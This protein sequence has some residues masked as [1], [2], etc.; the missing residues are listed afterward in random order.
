MRMVKVYKNNRYIYDPLYGKIYLPEFIWDIIPCPELQRLRE[1]RLANINSLCLIGGAS[2][3]RYEHAIGTTHL[4]KECI[5]SWPLLNPISRNEQKLF[6]LAA[7]LHD[8]TSAAF[9]HSVEYIE[10]R[11]GFEHDKSFKYAVM[12]KEK[13]NYQYKSATLEPI[14]YGMRRE[15]PSKISKE[16]FETIA[17]IISGKG[18]LGPLINS[19]M[20]LDNI[21][22]VFRLAYHI[23]IAKPGETPLKIA[24]S[25]YIENDKLIVRKEA[26]PF[27]EEWYE[28]RRKLYSLF[29]FNPEEFSAK[30]MLS[31]AIELARKSDHSFNWYDT[32]YEL[33]QKLSRISSET[34]LICSRLMK[35]DLYGCI[36]IFS[37]VKTDKYGTF[38]DRSRREE[39]E[40]ELR[41]ILR[42]KLGS[43]FKSAMV[44]I[45][46]IV[47]VNKAKRKVSLQA[48]DGS[49]VQIGT[50]SNQLLIGVFFK[51]ANL[52]MYKIYNIP[53]DTM[54]KIRNEISTYLSNVLEDPN[55]QEIE[56]YGEAKDL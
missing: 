17:E 31:E 13:A 42:K 35:A 38:S 12:R 8:V 50:S 15:L 34:S 18:R 36:V 32:D 41:K 29:L 49:A 22:N 1:I 47:D 20:D 44:A 11:Y 55:L 45:H 7:L 2:I 39:L 37:T 16:D 6:M 25:L 46:S 56:L 28:V 54:N 43:S 52:N 27:I 24:R 5:D 23:G 9:G 30:C 33:L 14:F 10:S 51:N 4:A 26:I 53:V 21:D 40:K 3:N 48:D 19:A